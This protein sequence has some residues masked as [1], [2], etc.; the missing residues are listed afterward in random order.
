MTDIA[1][2]DADA[3]A[4]AGCHD[5]AAQGIEDTADAVPASVDGGLASAILGQ[6]LGQLATHADDLALANRAT[7]AVMRS[8]AADYFGTDEGVGT[9]FNDLQEETDLGGNP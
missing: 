7:A 2:S 5:Q 8:V 1:I 4:I 3:E 9:A 6:I